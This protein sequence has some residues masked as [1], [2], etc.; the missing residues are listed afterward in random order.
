MHGGHKAS[1]NVERACD[2][3][4][5]NFSRNAKASGVGA[6]NMGNQSCKFLSRTGS[7]GSA[8]SGLGLADG[9]VPVDLGWLCQGFS[10][11][12][13]VLGSF[14]ALN[15]GNQSC[16][17]LSRIGSIG[18]AGAGLGLAAGLVPVGLGWLRLWIGSAGS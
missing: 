6:L 14:G 13:I 1:G 2:M 3:S 7:I 4:T 18:S 17:F 5:S 10:K 12:L 15:R 11:R 9:L 16:K 8:G